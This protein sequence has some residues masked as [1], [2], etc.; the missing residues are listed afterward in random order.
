[1]R[2]V[3][4]YGMP[5]RIGERYEILYCWNA[6]LLHGSSVCGFVRFDVHWS[7]NNG[8]SW[9]QLWSGAY[10]VADFHCCV[11]HVFRFLELGRFE[12]RAGR[13]LTVGRLVWDQ[14]KAGSTPVALTMI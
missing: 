10:C 5:R 4:A 14:E 9:S 2:I 3:G 12:R 7:D 8:Y 1:M 13:S 6:C 11:L